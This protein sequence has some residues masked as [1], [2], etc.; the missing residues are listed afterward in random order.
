MNDHEW[1]RVHSSE[2]KHEVHK[3]KDVCKDIVSLHG[4]MK[5]FIR[6]RIR[7]NESNGNG[8]WVV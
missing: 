8:Q 2:W 7:S 6:E 1:S 4:D 3:R 5:Q